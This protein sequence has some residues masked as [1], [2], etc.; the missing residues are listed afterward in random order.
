MK[1]NDSKSVGRIG[2]DLAC[3]FLK[4]KG[5]VI[6]DR[7]Y[8]ERWG[9]LDIVAKKDKVLHFVEVKTISTKGDYMPEDNVR[10]WKKERTG[11]II[12]T[13]MLDKHISDETD[14]EI[15]VIAIKL[16][17]GQKKARIKLINNILLL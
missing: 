7:N 4:S 1:Q 14:F 6:L 9:E 16:D 5:F 2:E 11:R 17:F 12:R 3:S 10:M 8:R 13:Y 15:D